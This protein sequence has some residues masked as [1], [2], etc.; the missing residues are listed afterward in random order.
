MAPDNCWMQSQRS[1]P[2][3]NAPGRVWLRVCSPLMVADCAVGIGALRGCVLGAVAGRRDTDRS[4][5]IDKKEFGAALKAMMRY[6]SDD[7]I[8]P[9]VA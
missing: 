8:P 4:G 2:L 9:G 5:S 7:V 1:A 6:G 3:S